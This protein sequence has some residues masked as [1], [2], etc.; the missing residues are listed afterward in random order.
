M[1]KKQNN[2]RLINGLAGF[3]M[4]GVGVWLALS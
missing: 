2:I 1:L 4:V 3:L